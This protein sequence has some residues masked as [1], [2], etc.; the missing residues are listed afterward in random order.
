[1]DPQVQNAAVA[2]GLVILGLLGF[3]VVWKITQSLLKLLLWL[4]ALLL[5]C[6]GAVWLLGEANVIPRPATWF[7]PRA[8]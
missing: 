3:V 7:G 4:V 1:M 8:A 6:G 5:L 2:V